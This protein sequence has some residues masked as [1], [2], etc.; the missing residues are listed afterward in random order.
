MDDE[1]R[2][3]LPGDPH[4]AQ[5]GERAKP[6]ATTRRGGR[7]HGKAPDFIRHFAQR[8]DD[9]FPAAVPA[10]INRRGRRFNRAADDGLMRRAPIVLIPL[11]LALALIFGAY[12]WR[13]SDTLPELGRVTGSGDPAV[14]GPFTL[15]DQNGKTRSSAEFRGR[16]MLI[17]FGYS[18][19]PDVCPTTLAMLSDAL[20]RLGSE[21]AR[22]VPIFITV[23]PARDT[24]AQL[25]SYLNAVAPGFLGLTGDEKTIT[26]VAGHFLVTFKK[27]PLPGGGYGMTHT[28]V[29]F[30]MGP[31]GRF[32][33]Y[34]DDT[35]IGPGRLA[36][37]LRARL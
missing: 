27:E 29:I 37:E 1:Q 32:A 21:R 11:L 3:R 24:P 6:D 28:N 25:K 7:R 2:R 5:V 31:D 13:V 17:Y 18:H 23:D 12:V 14:G 36:Q 4:P 15:T 30:L 26:A 9:L 19:C 35:A 8:S 22:I 33:T 10:I 16:F 20:S 34:W